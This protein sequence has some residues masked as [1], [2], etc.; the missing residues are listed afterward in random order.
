MY[1]IKGMYLKKGVNDH[2]NTRFNKMEM[3]WNED[4]CV[5]IQLISDF[6]PKKSLKTY[7]LQC[8]RTDG[9]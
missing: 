6:F 8:K 1:K 7:I 9:N 4:E 5:L 3:K 2:D